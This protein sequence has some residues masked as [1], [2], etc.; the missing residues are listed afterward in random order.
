ME[1][2]LRN[3]FIDE[4]DA[5][6]TGLR[7]ST[8]LEKIMRAMDKMFGLMEN[9]PKGDGKQ[10]LEFMN[11]S[12]PG[13]TLMNVARATGSRQDLVVEGADPVHFNGVCCRE[14]LDGK[15][16]CGDIILA[17]NLFIVLSL[18]E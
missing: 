7:V 12:H 15:S 8:S 6:D 16:W 2:H 1:K 14:H 9:D 11:V 13:A 4:L 3:K 17:E 18:C 5:I 10:F